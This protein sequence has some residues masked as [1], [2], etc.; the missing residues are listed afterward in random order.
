MARQ[1]SLIFEY[2][3][4]GNGL[5]TEAKTHS[6]NSAVIIAKIIKTKHW[7]IKLRSFHPRNPQNNYNRSVFQII[8]APNIINNP[9]C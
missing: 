2:K 6:D 3:L 8:T 9:S 1:P 7:K 5:W 4:P